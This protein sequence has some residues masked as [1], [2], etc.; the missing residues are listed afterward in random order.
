MLTYFAFDAKQ[1]NCVML[2]NVIYLIH[3]AWTDL[4]ASQI[5]TELSASAVSMTVRRI[6]AHS[7]GSLRCGGRSVLES[8]FLQVESECWDGAPPD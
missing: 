5:A 3:W 1:L 8:V 4:Q 6:L 7:L 2:Y